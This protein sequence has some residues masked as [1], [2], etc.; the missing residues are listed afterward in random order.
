MVPGLRLF[1]VARTRQHRMHRPRVVCGSH[2]DRGA[3]RT[4]PPGGGGL[5]LPTGTF[6][7]LAGAAGSVAELGRG[8]TLGQTGVGSISG[9]LVVDAGYHV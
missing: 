1:A 7:K 8:Q 4:P 5:S 6:S 3:R 2:H 9:R